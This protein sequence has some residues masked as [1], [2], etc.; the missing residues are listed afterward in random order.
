[1]SIVVSS[2]RKQAVSPVEMTNWACANGYCTASGT[3]HSGICGMARHYGLSCSGPVDV[4]TSNVQPIINALASG[5]SL[6]VVLASPGYFTTGGHF[7]VLTGVGSDNKIT[8]AD[9]ASRSRTGETF[10]MDFLITPSQGHV[11]KYWIISG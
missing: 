1:M 10:T 5:N 7:F 8:I 9:P 4:T 2:F 11:V 3:S 6:V